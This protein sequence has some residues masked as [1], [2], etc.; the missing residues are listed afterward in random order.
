M[1]TTQITV[2]GFV[3]TDVKFETSSGGH[4]VATFRLASTPRKVGRD[5]VWQNLEPNWFTVKVWR[6]VAENVERSVRRGHAVVVRGRLVTETWVRQDGSTS[7]TSVIEA[8]WLGH[9]LTKGTTRFERRRPAEREVEERAY[10]EPTGDIE[11]AESFDEALES[12]ALAADEREDRTA[13]A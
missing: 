9:D 11:P 4:P 5:G 1:S 13:A 6:E 12:A 10:A 8:E 3:G 7:S 2:Q